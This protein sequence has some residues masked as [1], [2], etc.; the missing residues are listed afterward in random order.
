MAFKVKNQIQKWPSEDF[1]FENEGDFVEGYLVET[2]ELTG[3][4]G[5]MRGKKFK[6]YT[7]KT[8]D[9]FVNF[10]GGTVIDRGLSDTQT[11]TLIRVTYLGE[12]ESKDGNNYKNFKI[13]EDTDSTI[14]VAALAAAN[15]S[16]GQS[17]A[18]IVNKARVG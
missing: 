14:D 7:L 12:A 9:G 18:D 8:D 2:A 15:K 10:L 3:K 11:G 17:A 13:E 6:K 16:T 4:K 1:A 5:K